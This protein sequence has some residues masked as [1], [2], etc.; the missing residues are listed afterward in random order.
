MRTTPTG[1]KYKKIDYEI[2]DSSQMPKETVD[3]EYT[4]KW[5]FDEV[6]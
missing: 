2:V 6:C 4:T 3:Q 5:T 1:A